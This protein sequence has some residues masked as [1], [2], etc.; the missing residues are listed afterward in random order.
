MTGEVVR[1]VAEA[2]VN[3]GEEHLR[4]RDSLEGTEKGVEMEAAV[5]LSKGDDIDLIG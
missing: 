4:T 3:I 1:R 2:R 5:A